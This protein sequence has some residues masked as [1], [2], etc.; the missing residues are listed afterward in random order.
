MAKKFNVEKVKIDVINSLHK[1]K[2]YNKRHTPITHVCKRLPKIPCK[3]IKN[4]I[5]ELKKEEIIK[6]KPTYHGKDVY[7]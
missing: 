3:Y 2:Y 4:A 7:L 1:N 6:I 5:N